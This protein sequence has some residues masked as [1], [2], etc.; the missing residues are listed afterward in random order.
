MEASCSHCLCFFPKEEGIKVEDADKE[1]ER[2]INIDACVQ[3]NSLAVVEY[4]DDI[5][6]FHNKSEV[7]LM[8]INKKFAVLKLKHQ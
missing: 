5:F 8:F 6:N 1:N 2:V 3:K 7:S 4:I